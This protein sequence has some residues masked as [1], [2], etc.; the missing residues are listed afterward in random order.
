MRVAVISCWKY[1]DAWDAFFPLFKK[2]WPDCHSPVTLITDLGIDKIER[3]WTPPWT[4]VSI[5]KQGQDWCSALVRFLESD[6]LTAD[7]QPKDAPV[8]LLQ[9]DF[10]LNAPVNQSLIEHA[11]NQMKSR[12]AGMIRLYPCPGADEDYGDPHYGIVKKGS[13]YRISCQASIWRPDY[14][15]AIASR[16]GSTPR[17]FELNG[18]KIAESLPDEVLAFKRDSGPWPIQYYCS[19]IS[20][21]KWNPQA[22][23]FCRQQ[24]I[25]VDLSLRE[26]A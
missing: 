1:R 23:E 13:K 24:G 12:N 14:L 11:L 10:L 19:A 18:T 17:D 8:L 7:G 3:A 21:G 5:S 2:F 26:I 9:E 22:L 4:F 15:H 6:L 16:C 25:S 20:A